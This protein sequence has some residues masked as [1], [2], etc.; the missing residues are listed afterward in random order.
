M[1]IM[2]ELKIQLQLLTIGASGLYGALYIIKVIHEYVQGFLYFPK[3]GNKDK[4]HKNKSRGSTNSIER[5]K[6][7]K[8]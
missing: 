5:I 3:W 4:I 1:S 7:K 6:K 8:S 2:K